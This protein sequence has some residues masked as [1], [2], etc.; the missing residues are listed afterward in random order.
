MERKMKIKY[1]YF[2]LLLGIIQMLL[3]QK[4]FTGVEYVYVYKVMDNRAIIVRKNGDI[5][6]IEKGIGCLSLWRYEGKMVLIK[7]PGIFLGIGSELLIPELN[8]KCRILN[9][10][11]LGS[12]GSFNSPL[13]TEPEMVTPEDD[14]DEKHWIRYKSDDGSIIILE[15]GSVWEVNP[16]DRIYSILWLPTD[17]VIICNGKMINLDNGEKVNVKKLK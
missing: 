17:D 13:F 1:V 2:A 14:C 4:A 16:I 3:T 10:E 12:I 8:Q 15:D 11:Y 9:S 5:Y 6:L 7:S